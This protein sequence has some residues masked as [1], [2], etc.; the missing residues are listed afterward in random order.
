MYILQQNAN[1]ITIIIK[2]SNLTAPSCR[3]KKYHFEENVYTLR[4]EFQLLKNYPVLLLFFYKF[5]KLSWK[6]SKI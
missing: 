1:P 6:E 5:S 2:L 3:L 4:A